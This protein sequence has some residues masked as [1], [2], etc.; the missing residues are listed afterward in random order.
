MLRMPF[1]E[2]MLPPTVLPSTLVVKNIPRP[3]TSAP[4]STVF[5]KGFRLPSS[6]QISG[7]F[8]CSLRFSTHSSERRNAIPGACPCIE[9]PQ[10]PALL[11]DAVGW[12]ETTC[13]SQETRYGREDFILRTMT[14]STADAKYS[15]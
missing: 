14:L 13:T 1:A 10:S 7:Y 3:F 15:R 11:V 2:C 5:A 8:H 12:G 6:F 4:Y 9:M